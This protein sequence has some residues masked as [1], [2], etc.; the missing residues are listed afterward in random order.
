L[1]AALEYK[2]SPAE[3]KFVEHKLYSYRDNKRLIEEYMAQREEIIHSTKRREPGLP[4]NPGVGR[5]VETTVIQMLVLEQKANREQFW[6][7]AIEDVYELL[8]EEDKKLVNLKYFE[9]YLTNAGV[10]RALNISEREFYRRRERTVLRFANR[11]G[12]V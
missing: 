6:V 5:P 7:K 10:A 2:L 11:F 9:G 8:P 12:L 3:F 4:G 1:E